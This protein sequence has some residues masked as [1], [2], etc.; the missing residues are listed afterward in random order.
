MVGSTTMLMTLGAMVMLG[1]KLNFFNMVVL[2]TM[3]GIGVDHGVHYYRRWRELGRDT[4]AAQRELFEP[5][6]VC[7]LTTVMGYV[8][9]NVAHHPGLEAIGQLA[10]VGLTA[11]WV[12]GVF[13]M[14][15]LLALVERRARAADPDEAAAATDAA[16]AAE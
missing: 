7:S 6:T 16:V 13:L 2:P 15:G 11:T 14:P 3:L 12:T 8:G 4:R 5:L 1:W 9:M 10:V